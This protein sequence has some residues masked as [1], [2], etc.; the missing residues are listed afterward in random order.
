[1]VELIV[2]EHQE[3]MESYSFVVVF[4][5]TQIETLDWAFFFNQELSKVFG[6]TSCFCPIFFQF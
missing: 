5:S 2:Q 4:E 1:M 3:L 6:W